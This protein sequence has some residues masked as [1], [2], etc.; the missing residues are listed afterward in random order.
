MNQRTRSS[1][2]DPTGRIQQNSLYSM[3]YL[4]QRENVPKL[5]SDTNI[6]ISSYKD[7]IIKDNTPRVSEVTCTSYDRP[8][9][10]NLDRI[11][12]GYLTSDNISN[13]GI[14][15][16]GNN[17]EISTHYRENKIYY[18]DEKSPIKYDPTLYYNLVSLGYRDENGIN[19][20]SDDQIAKFG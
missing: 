13:P 3:F 17:Y 10:S 20:Y 5:I 16:Q 11:Y 6:E 12:I 8:T 9:Y 4:K 7:S 2:L 1:D 19:Q 15:D 18:F 14:T